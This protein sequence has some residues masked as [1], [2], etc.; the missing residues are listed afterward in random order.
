MDVLDTTRVQ[1]GL[2]DVRGSHDESV[3]Q[4]SRVEIVLLLLLD[5]LSDEVLFECGSRRD[6]SNSGIEIQL[7]SIGDIS[8]HFDDKTR[9]SYYAVVFAH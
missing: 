5:L 4:G 2:V 1:G 7:G 3:L 8:S 9:V 6:T